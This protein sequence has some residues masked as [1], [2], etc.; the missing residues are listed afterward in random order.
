M[1]VFLGWAD[2]EAKA[3][4]LALKEWL[5]LVCPG[6]QPW[7]SEDITKGS[8]WSAEI[9]KTLRQSKAGIFV[10]TP[11]NLTSVWLHYEA[12]AISNVEEALVCTFLRRVDKAAVRPPL[13]VFQHTT[14]GD[15]DDTRQLV[16]NL[17]ALLPAAERQWSEGQLRTAFEKWWPD[18]VDKLDAVEP[19]KGGAAAPK[20]STDEMLS[21]LLGLVRGLAASRESER[22][23]EWQRKWAEA[24][25]AFTLE[26]PSDLHGFWTET[27]ARP[28]R[29]RRR[30]ATKATP[31]PLLM[32]P[33][34]GQA[35][36]P[37]G[38]SGP[39]RNSPAAEAGARPAEAAAAGEGDPKE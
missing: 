31:D 24:L 23:A 1:R 5:P 25:V 39:R 38:T 12:G 21:E 17:A 32:T 11:D 13:D 7:I 20:P 29:L 33:P 34:P 18:L 28:A 37:A 14:A 6:L 19:L 4:A 10:L 15:S 27:F 8:R 36:E 26:R 35:A 2:S 22:L 30:A 3:V 9:A 16:A